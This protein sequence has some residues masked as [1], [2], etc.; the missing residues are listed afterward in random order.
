VLT[1]HE[2]FVQ[3]HSVVVLVLA[4]LDISVPRAAL[5]VEDLIDRSGGPREEEVGHDQ[6]ILR[7]QRRQRLCLLTLP[8]LLLALLLSGSEGKESARLLMQMPL[9]EGGG[10]R[11]ARGM[12]EQEKQG[13]R[14]SVMVGGGRK[15]EVV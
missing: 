5:E 6:H 13:W 12:L 2:V 9:A 7:G 1:L 4:P 10:Q 14:W 11:H 8:D 3:Q 15:E